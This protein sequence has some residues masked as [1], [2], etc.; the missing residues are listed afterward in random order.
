MIVVDLA[1]LL[2]TPCLSDP[3]AVGFPAGLPR[4]SLSLPSPPFL[5]R[6]WFWLA[7]RRDEGRTHYLENTVSILQ[8]VSLSVSFPADFVLPDAP[9]KWGIFY[10]ISP[11][12]R[13]R[14]ALLCPTCFRTCP[15]IQ[16]W[17]LVVRSGAGR[18]PLASGQFSAPPRACPAAKTLLLI[19]DDRSLW[20]GA[21]GGR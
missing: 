10:S 17:Q 15:R 14:G 20:I 7:R 21:R 1:L 19:G 16:D 13:P 12:S 18:A 9:E 6:V 11:R 3:L 5:V 2:P 4:G 8:H